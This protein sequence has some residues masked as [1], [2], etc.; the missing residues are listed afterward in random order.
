MTLTDQN[1]FQVGNI[2]VAV[3]P[4][5]EVNFP[6]GWFVEGEFKMSDCNNP[7]WWSDGTF[8]ILNSAADP[9]RSFGPDM[10][11][12]PPARQI[13]Y[14]TPADG[15]RWMESVHQEP[16]GTLYGWYHN[17]PRE[18]IPE[19]VQEGRPNRLTA[20]RIGAAVSRD[21][22]ATW[23]DLGIV[24]E[25]PPDSLNYN[26]NNFFFA[27]GNG[28]FSVILD[29]KGEYF[30]FLFG[31]YYRNVAQQGVSIARL[32]F[33]DRANPVGKVQKWY[34]GQW[35]EPGIGGRV[36][37]IL[38]VRSD[39]HSENPDAIWGPSVHWN[40]HLE[41]YV[42][43]LNRAVDPRWK[44]EGIYITTTPDI[45]DPNSWAEPVRILEGGHWYPQVVGTDTAKQE[46]EREAG[47]VARLF[48]TGTSNYELHFSR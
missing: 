46:T 15:W 35:Q 40:T 25:S 6:G 21:N 22:G 3:H 19:H 34:Q 4:A 28:D 37:P 24:I 1:Q 20:P 26:T 2:Q 16:D 11:N 5:E 41:Q 17:E 47:R 43:L 36:T 13:T 45:S 29:R 18:L 39:W 12:L 44:Q 10:Y 8:Y 27:G 9:W 30:T 23:D 32:P 38:P 42:I 31:T 7:C 33:A 14:T 48:I